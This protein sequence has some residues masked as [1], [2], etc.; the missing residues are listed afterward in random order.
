MTASSLPA[1]LC[2]AADGRYAIEA[3]TG[4]IIDHTSWLAREDFTRF[5]Y[6]GVSITAPQ[7]PNW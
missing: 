3:A 1:A 6:V 4:L 5:I 2:A 7:A